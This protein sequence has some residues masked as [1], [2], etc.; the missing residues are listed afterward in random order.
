MIRLRQVALVATDLDPVVD[1]LCEALGLEVGFRD[2]GVAE[3]G[4]VN[5]LMPIGDTFLEVVAPSQPNTTAGRLL[6]KR[7]GGGGYMVILQ[8]DD[9]ERRRARLADLG[10]R[11][12]WRAD[13]PT[14][15]GTHLHPRDVGGA[16]LSL[17]QAEP[18]ASWA[19][20]GS[21]WEDHIRQ[22]V[23]TG[24][25]GVVIGADDP[26]KMARRWAEVIDAPTSA[27]GTAVELSWGVIRF[28]PAGARGEGVD[29]VELSAT[30]RS[31]A[32]EVLELAGVQIRLV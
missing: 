8:C 2:P 15:A 10:V 19:W 31:R 13:L 5:A 18:T 23:V 20:A 27:D 17:D 29:G 1:S 32:G 25:T 9:L 12:I 26:S 3:F 16:I 4:L 7:G 11:V 22:A 28:E 30:R 24:I 21:K 14:V 6:D